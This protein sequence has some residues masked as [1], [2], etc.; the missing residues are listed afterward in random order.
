MS[1]IR[2]G[3]EDNKSKGKAD[4]KYDI[5]GPN[6]VRVEY[7]K[8]GCVYKLAVDRKYSAYAMEALIC[9]KP[10]SNDPN[11]ACDLNAISNPDNVAIA[12]ELDVLLIS[13]DSDNH[14]NNVLWS[15]DLL[16]GALQRILSVPYGAEVTSPYYYNNIN[17]FSYIIAEDQHPYSG[18]E[19]KVSSPL[20]SGKDAFLG[21]WTWPT[22]KR[23]YAAAFLPITPALTEAEKHAVRG[24]SK[25][26][27]WTYGKP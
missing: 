13:E 11:N 7:N 17:G 8:C 15:Y 27:V 14:E 5:G 20:F 2:Y 18:N 26:A 3:M 24:T 1:D 22:V 16:R 4:T 6:H 9:G 21:Y 23:S 10:I 25:V 19:D 12:A